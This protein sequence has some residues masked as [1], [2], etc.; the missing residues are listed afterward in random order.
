MKIFEEYLSRHNINVPLVK[1]D[2]GCLILKTDKK[3]CDKALGCQNWCVFS[4]SWH[5]QG[6][7]PGQYNLS[8]RSPRSSNKYQDLK[9]LINCHFSF[10]KKWCEYEEFLYDWTNSLEGLTPILDEKE[11]ILASWEIF[12]C[13]NESWFLKQSQ[14]LKKSL[15]KTIDLESSSQF[16]YG[17]LEDF[18]NIDIFKYSSAHNIWKNNFLKLVKNSGLIGYNYLNWLGELIN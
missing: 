11:K 15:F 12:V 7:R 13:T 1:H 17:S 9:N 10:Q 6:V 14:G 5:D 16:R 2:Q 8:L 4:I 18:Q 3:F